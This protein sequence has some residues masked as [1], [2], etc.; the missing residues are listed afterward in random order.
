MAFE[1][2][3]VLTGEACPYNHLRTSADL[4][5]QQHLLDRSI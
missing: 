4:F 2:G 5:Q 1:F 3:T